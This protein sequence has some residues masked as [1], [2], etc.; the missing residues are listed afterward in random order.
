MQRIES[1]A[2]PLLSHSGFGDQEPADC[3][4]QDLEDLH[5][6][7]LIRLKKETRSVPRRGPG[8]A[9]QPVWEE[10]F[11][12][13]TV[14]GFER[15]EL[16]HRAAEAERDPNEGGTG[17][18]DWETEVL[19]VLQAFYTASGSADADLGVSDNTVNEV[20]GREPGDARTDR[21][22]SML[23]TTGYLDTKAR[24]MGFRYCQITE[25][26]LQ[27]TA[28]SPSGA[29]D[30]AYTR[31]LAL[32]DEHVEERPRRMRSARSGSAFA[33][34]S[35]ASAETSP[36]MFSAASHRPAC[37]IRAFSYT[38]AERTVRDTARHPRD[39][40]PPLGAVRSGCKR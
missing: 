5:E 11:F 31:L 26:G 17:G 23:V 13:V 10:W 25:K 12:D 34:A 37:G 28:G 33:L 1:H 20:L 14:A 18:Y 19:P 21:V 15:V 9:V 27:I 3:N 8:R 29:A 7:G 22:L 24:S 38:R 32:I 35:S 30:A 36:S 2:G 6:Q 4:L 39:T 40:R 16:Q